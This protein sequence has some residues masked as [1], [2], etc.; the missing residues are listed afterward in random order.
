MLGKLTIKNYALIE[1]LDISLHQGLNIITGET[2]AGKSIIM[3]AL[4]L[5]LGNRAEGK[6]FFDDSRKCVIEGYF[7]IGN[8]QLRD[9]FA[10]HDLDYE[11]ETI[12]RREIAVDGKSRAFVNDSPVTLN[13]LRALG[14]Q[15]IDIHSQHA[16]LQ[17]TT[18]GFQLL[19]LDSVAKNQAIQQEYQVGLKQYRQ[20]EKA[21]KEL[22]EIIAAAT[23]EQDF[24]QFQFDELDAANLQ[25]GEEEALEEEQGQ[26]EHADEIKRGLLAATFLLDE[27]EYAVI[28][29]LKEAHQQLQSLE[30]FLSADNDLAAR[31]QSSLIEIKDISQEIASLEQQ[32]GIDQGRLDFVNERLS[33]LYNLKKKHRAASLAELIVLRETLEHK[34]QVTANQEQELQKAEQQVAESLTKLSAVALRLHESRKAKIKEV[35]AHVHA[36][37][38]TVGMPNAQLQ[39]SLNLLSPEK[40]K[41]SG[42]DEVQ[43]LFSANKGQSLQQIHKVASGGELSRLMLAI[44]SL[45]AKSSS[46][47]TIIFDEID[48]GISGEVALKV[49][50]IME[51][52]ADR[53]QVMAITHL[54]QIASKGEAHFKVYKFDEGDKTKSSIVRLDKEERIKEV[55]Q[56]LS[57]SRPGD[58]A[59]AHAKQ[60]IYGEA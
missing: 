32:I 33:V 25:E 13:I 47:P 9:F 27:Q 53:M 55:A 20:H 8:Y 34:L 58:A 15:L 16:T 30:K 51:G 56:M 28:Q 12:I 50:E 42:G 5:I 40:Y 21:L 35:E 38:T 52:L 26:L 1:N 44:K 17:I 29:R 57:G 19:V 2:G 10:E 39:I 11:E 24:N 43:F 7:Q 46:L 37:L 54:P 59:L 31:L 22:K 60:L 36:V 18:E 45:I 3:G 14:E 49:G 6:H 48:T 23:M 4:G 41:T